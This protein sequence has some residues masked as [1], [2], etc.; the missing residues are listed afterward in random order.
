MTDFWRTVLQCVVLSMAPVVELRGALP[1]AIAHGLP[2]WLSYFLCVFSNMIP[3]PFIL[4]FVKKLLDWMKTRKHLAKYALW[5]ENHAQIKLDVYYKY[6]LLGLFVLVAI[7]LP[8][9]GAWTGAL[10]AALLG[11][12]RKQASLMI[13]LGVAAAGAIMLAV[14]LGAV[15]VL[16]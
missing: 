11:I 3:V 1:W 16:G 4:L 7:P 6:K 12:Q 13:L 8:G 9:T 14:S 5:I 10:V 15:A 2:V